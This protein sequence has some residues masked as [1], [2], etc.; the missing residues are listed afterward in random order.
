MTSVCSTSSNSQ[1]GC[2]VADQTSAHAMTSVCSTSSK[3]QSTLLFH[4]KV[5]VLYVKYKLVGSS[6]YYLGFVLIYVFYKYTESLNLWTLSVVL[7][8]NLQWETTA[9]RDQPLMRDYFCNNMVLHFYIFVPQM[10]DHLSYKTT[11]CGPVGWSFV[12]GF[13]VLNYSYYIVL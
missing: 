12:T 10:K 8:W 2:S 5:C 6:L 1:P 13:T 9:M 7:L 4:A 11:F 3:Y